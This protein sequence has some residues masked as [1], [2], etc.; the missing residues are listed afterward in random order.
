MEHNEEERRQGYQHGVFI[1][2]L[3]RNAWRLMPVVGLV[4]VFIINWVKG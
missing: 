4:I 1:R 3:E 2:F